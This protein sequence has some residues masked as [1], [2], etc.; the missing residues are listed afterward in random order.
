MAA[1]AERRAAGEESCRTMEEILARQQ[2][3][4]GIPAGL[5]PGTRVAHKTGWITAM[6][7]DAAIVGSDATRR[8]VLV[9]LVRGLE[10]PDAA[11]RLTAQ[12]AR[13]IHQHVTRPA[14]QR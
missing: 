2:F 10:D 1:I 8:Y 7:H 9:V 14:P 5:P 12:V 4:T 3:N 6:R 13:L 11:D